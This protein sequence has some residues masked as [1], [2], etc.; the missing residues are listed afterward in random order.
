MPIGKMVAP[1]LVARSIVIAILHSGHGA[2][3]APKRMI[4]KASLLVRKRSWKNDVFGQLKCPQKKTVL[5]TYVF[6]IFH[7]YLPRTTIPDI[8]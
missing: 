1:P 6:L 7:R 8:P 5:G 2:C 3:Q 4:K